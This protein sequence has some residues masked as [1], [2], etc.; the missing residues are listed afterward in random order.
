MNRPSRRGAQAVEFA[1]LS[2][3]FVGLILSVCNWGLFFQNSMTVASVGLVLFVLGGGTGQTSAAF[4]FLRI[5][6]SAK[7]FVL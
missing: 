6:N 7:T 4:D 2:P 1:L 3:V 5:W